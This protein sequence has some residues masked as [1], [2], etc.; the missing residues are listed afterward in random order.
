MLCM[1]LCCVCI[2]CMQL[3]IP[4]ASNVKEYYKSYL[5]RKNTKL[6]KGSKIIIQQPQTIKN[7]NIVDIKSVI[8]EHPKTSHK[9]SKAIRHAK[10]F[11]K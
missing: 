6:F 1:Y 10:T 11:P 8:I 5:N 9:L 2:Y 7:P 3:K 4:D